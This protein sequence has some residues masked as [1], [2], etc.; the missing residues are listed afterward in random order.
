MKNTSVD[1]HLPDFN[2]IFDR[3]DN[4][5]RNGYDITQATSD[6]SL[7]ACELKRRMILGLCCVLWYW[8]SRIITELIET[9]ITASCG[10]LA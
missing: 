1:R 3:I 4:R 2:A 5:K 6:L 8:G 9:Y 10:L 7:S